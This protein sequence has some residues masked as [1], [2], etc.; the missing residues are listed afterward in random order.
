MTR[1]L[2]A[3]LLVLLLSALAP[4]QAADTFSFSNPP[5]PHAVG[6]KVVQQYDRTR[7]YKAGIDLTTGEPTRGERAR[8]MQAL[9]WYPAARGGQPV[10]MR[11]YLALTPTEDDFT[12]SAA[13]V[14]RLADT[15]IERKAGKRRDALLRELRRPMLAVRDARAANGSF[16]VVIYAPSFSASAIENTDLCEFLASHGYIVLAGPSLGARTRQMTSDLDGLEAQA[17]DIAWLIGH[18]ASLPQADTNKVA[19]VGFSWGGLSNVLAAAKDQR[20]QAIVSLD[21]SVRGFREF[22]DGGKDA[23]RYVTPARVAVPMLYVGRRPSTFEELNRNEVDTRYSFMNQ[24]AYS[25]VTIVTMMPMKHMDF[26]SYHLRT[27]QDDEFGDYTRDEV[28]LAHS[29]SARYV[30]HFLDAHLKND[31]AGL[32]F[33][34]KQPAANQAP[35]HMMSVDIRRA[36][37]KPAPTLENFVARLAAEGFDKAIPLYDGF[38][39]RDATFK[40]GPN[41]IYGWGVQLARLGRHAQ[42]R[43]IFRLGTHLNPKDSP[44]FDAVAE[45]QAKLGQ[46]DDAVRSYRRVLELDPSNADAASYLKAHAP[47]KAGAAPP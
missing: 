45:M 36:S 31:G 30:R 22:I 6:L 40:L 29:W 20:I 9:V 3:F 23:A 37:G 10:S 2:P 42:A 47:A 26:S 15:Q 13:E 44:M 28:A 43:E 24:M 8:P 35:P 5:G 14:E 46:V 33:I 4:A 41:D 19:V 38:A 25:D 7:L 1:H 16:P 39:A 21:G 12:H 11:D 27:A 34:D 32:A 17:G 18:A